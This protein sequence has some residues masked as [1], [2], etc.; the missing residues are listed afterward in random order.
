MKTFSNNKF[1]KEKEDEKMD[2]RSN[3]CTAYFEHGFGGLCPCGNP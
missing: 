1:Q 2:V 3:R